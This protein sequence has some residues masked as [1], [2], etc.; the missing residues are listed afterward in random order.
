MGCRSC[1]TADL[2]TFRQLFPALNTV[3][4]TTV[5]NNL[6][7]AG[8]VLDENQWGCTLAEAQLYLAAHQIAWGQNV[9]V[10]S[11]VDG[12][13][14][15]ISNP[16][17]GSLTSASADGLSVSYGASM[18]KTSGNPLDAYYSST[19]YGVAFLAL[20]YRQMP[21]GTLAIT[22]TCGSDGFFYG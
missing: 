7:S 9:Q 14:N 11:N 2:T 12:N 18:Q 15:V 3:D 17:A 19:P 13:G 16:T 5:Q 22:N 20:K 4:D 21:I 8:C 6:D 10:A 1:Y